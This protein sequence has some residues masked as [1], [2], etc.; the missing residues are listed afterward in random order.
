MA[1]ARTGAPLIEVRGKIGNIVFQRFGDGLMMRERVVPDDRRT[2]AQLQSRALLLRISVLWKSL[3]DAQFEAWSTYAPANPYVAFTG[4]TC[5]WLRL[6]PDGTPPMLPPLGP[7]FGDAVN[8]WAQAGTSSAASDSPK[9]VSKAVIE[10]DPT[11]SP[12]PLPQEIEGE[13]SGTLIVN[14]T[15]PNATNVVT[16]ILVQKMANSRRK[17]RERGWVTVGY[18]TFATGNL[19]QSV[20]LAP[21]A[22]AVAYRFVLSTTGQTTNLVHLASVTI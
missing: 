12:S 15:Q 5:K 6:H 14:G 22:Y 11:P 19:S 20:P 21:G 7:F 4:L 18:L 16:E 17:S 3:T 8:V 10:V 9:T 2:T 1:T 13:G